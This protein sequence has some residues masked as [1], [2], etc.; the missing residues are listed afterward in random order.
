MVGGAKAFTAG[1]GLGVLLAAATTGAAPVGGLS[2][3]MQRVAT[4][5]EVAL[6][7][8][9]LLQ[10]ERELH[11][12]A[13]RLSGAEDT[14]HYREAEALGVTE[15]V[16][17]SRLP[18][19]TQR[20][21]AVAIV[22]EAKRNGIDPMLVV[23]V[24][25]AE[26]SFNAFAVS[27]VG[28]MGLMQVM[29]DTGAWLMD[30]RGEKLGPKSNLFDQELNIELGA[31]YLAELIE[32]FGTVEKA[33]VAYNAGPGAARKILAGPNR[34]K[35]VAGYPAKVIREFHKLK[36]QQ[37]ARAEVSTSAQRENA[38]VGGPAGRR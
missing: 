24:I 25:R 3:A 20:R 6:L 38:N 33:L 13:K 1:V 17:A 35:F 36:A 14:E 4:P 15:A 29:P 2:S 27:H 26:S 16:R 12:L 23:A 9:T 31:A 8:Q 10:R 22:R 32:R 34:A 7:E 21:L 19:A 30:R 11:E 37:L 5:E 18:A 28:A